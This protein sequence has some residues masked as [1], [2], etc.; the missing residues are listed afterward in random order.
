M[1]LARV[2]AVIVKESQ[3]ILRDPIT[4]GVALVIPVVMLM[5][6]GYAISLDVRDVRMG[7]WDQDGTPASRA[8]ADAFERS[9]YFRV[10]H[11]IGG[12]ADLRAALDRGR[13]TLALVVPARFAARLARGESAPVQIIVDGTYSNTAQIVAAY[14]DQIAARFGARA[15]PRIQPEVRVWFNAEMR[16]AN[17]VVPGLFGV[18]LLA[19]PPLLT[20][21]AVVREKETGSIQQVY[22]SPLTGQEFL[23]GKLLPYGLIALVQMLL[24]VGLGLVWFEVPVRGSLPL[25]L[26]VGLVYVLC[27]VGLGLLVSTVTRKQVVAMLL[28]LVLTLMPSFLF[29]GLLFPIFTMPY[30][31][32]LYADAFPGRYF[33]DLSRDV[34]MKG[35]TLADVWRSVLVLFLYTLAVFAL[36]AARFR[37][38]VA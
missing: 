32:Q 12:P 24:V 18:I 10:V 22:A 20:A 7:V 8:L 35:A 2:R 30:A 15:P 6:F 26:T 3:E 21:L 13:I 25:L 1:R 5:L 31:L 11:R 28:A 36:A 17:Y 33:V 37:K 14:A 16:S 9:G 29:S 23:L 27:T 4:L 34:V 38:K 19:L